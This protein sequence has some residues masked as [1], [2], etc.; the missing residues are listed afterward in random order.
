LGLKSFEIQ[1]ST[2]STLIVFLFGDFVDVILV[3][4]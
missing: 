1:A 3:R 2:H 4:N